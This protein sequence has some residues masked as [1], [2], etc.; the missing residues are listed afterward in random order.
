MLT[1]Q[2]QLSELFEQTTTQATSSLAG[3]TGLLAT[4]GRL[5]KY[6]F[7]EQLMIHAQN[8]NATVC[9]EYGLWNEKMGRYVL[10]GTK[11]KAT[12]KIKKSTEME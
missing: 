2:Q 3:W 10:R 12:T 8:P 5:Y 7:H 9:A 1:K 6:P 11:S 4:I